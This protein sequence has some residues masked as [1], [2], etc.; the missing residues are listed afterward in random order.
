MTASVTLVHPAK[1]REFLLRSE[2]ELLSLLAQEIS[3]RP[4][5]SFERAYIFG[6]AKRTLALGQGFRD[7]VDKGN[8]TVASTLVRI[9]LDTLLRLYALWW[10]ADSEAFAA[11][12]VGGVSINKM[13]AAS[14]ELMSD[15]HLYKRLATVVP[16]IETVYQESSGFVHFSGRHILAAIVPG[17]EEGLC[18]LAI[19]AL[20]PLRPPQ[21]LA[22]VEASFTDVSMR[23]KLGIEE[24]LDIL[25]GRSDPEE[26]L[27]VI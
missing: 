4:A 6:A 27:A 15:S 20:D 2:R 18:T 12:V 10:V 21:F 17:D 24:R 8:V 14:G 19:E 16:W 11:K 3:G 25:R 7:A 23:I 26:L 5:V 13:K 22:Q 1:A 9:N